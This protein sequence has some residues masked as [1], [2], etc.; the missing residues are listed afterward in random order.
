MSNELSNGKLL[1]PRSSE[2]V[3]IVQKISG[4]GVKVKV[5]ELGLTVVLSQSNQILIKVS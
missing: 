2:P 4:E 3:V 1:Y 5:V